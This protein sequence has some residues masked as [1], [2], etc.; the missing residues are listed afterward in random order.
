MKMCIIAL[1]VMAAIQVRGQA[2]TDSLY[3]VTYTTGHSWDASKM[4]NEQRYFSEHSANLAALRKTGIIR[5]GARY[6]DKGI[7]VIAV[8]SMKIAYELIHADQ[9]VANQLL[10]ADIQKFKVFY[11]GCIT[12]P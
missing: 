9:A 11:E 3:I 4:P 8:P 10:D 7:I 6:A 1:L 12:K 5:M 2:L